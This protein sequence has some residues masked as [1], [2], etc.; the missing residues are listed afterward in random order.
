MNRLS[1]F[2]VLGL[3]C[4]LVLAGCGESKEKK[5][6][7]KIGKR[8]DQLDSRVQQALMAK[9]N[10]DQNLQNL[11]IDIAKLQQDT[12]SMRTSVEELATSLRNLQ[13]EIKGLKTEQKD[14]ENELKKWGFWTWLLITLLFVGVVYALYRFL[15]P[16]PY[17][18]EDEEEDFADFEDDGGFDD[19]G[20]DKKSG[21][22]TPKS[23]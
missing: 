15:K 10:L 6:N 9:G 11:Q 18:D 22:D 3:I 7:D 14:F 21:D 4:C 19:L 23:V 13:D 5:F 1:I 20:G 16:K 17:E 8:A 2:A 12:Q